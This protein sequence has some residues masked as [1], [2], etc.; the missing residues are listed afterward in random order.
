MYST[1]SQ[2]YYWEG[3]ALD[4]T[5]LVNTCHRCIQ[6][7][8]RLKKRKQGVTLF[9]D[10]EPLEFVAIDLLGPLPKISFGLY[11]KVLVETN[12]LWSCV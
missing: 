2:K 10:S 3:L 11:P 8:T 9:P 5:R 12:Y 4:V 6:E 7:S 1:L